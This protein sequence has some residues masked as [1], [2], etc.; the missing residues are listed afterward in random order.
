MNKTNDNGFIRAFIAAQPSDHCRAF[1][2]AQ[3]QALIDQTLNQ[4]ILWAPPENFHI[5][6]KFLGQVPLEKIDHLLA[7]LNHISKH[8]CAFPVD[9]QS[10]RYFPNSRS[11]RFIVCPV[12]DNPLLKQ[13]VKNIENDLEILGYAAESR[14]FRGHMTLGRRHISEATDRIKM[15]NEHCSMEIASL[16]LMQSVQTTTGSLYKVIQ[17]IPFTK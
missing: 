6:L 9:I 12:E 10:A 14:P 11:G 13:L 8:T 2:L 15:S 17:A 3:Q 4:H 16:F 1:L 5:T 7:C